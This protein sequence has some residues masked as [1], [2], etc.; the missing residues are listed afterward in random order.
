MQPMKMESNDNSGH[1]DEVCRRVLAAVLTQVPFDGWTET[2]YARGLKQAGVGRGEA[3]LLLPQ[4]LYDVIEL[5]G[6][7]ADRH[8]MERV[9]DEPGFSRFRVREKVAFAVRARLEAM[10]PYRPAVKRLMVWYAMPTH[11]TSGFRRLCKTVDL[12]WRAAGDVS[13]DFN[14]YT[15]RMMLA[16][17]LKSTTLFWLDDETPG[18]RATWAFLDRRIA[19][20]MKFGKTISLLKEWSPMEIAE[21]LKARF[22]RVS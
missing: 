12:I 10:T 4:G 2:S 20:V 21:F 17:V 3:G 18:C 8:M 19:G 11:M 9:A 22:S 16:T 14:Y 15:K 13:T 5:L 7:E 6:A 1:K